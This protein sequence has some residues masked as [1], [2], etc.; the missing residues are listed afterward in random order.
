MKALWG[1]KGLCIQELTK[2]ES[3][4]LKWFQH[5]NIYDWMPVFTFTIF[6]KI[7]KQNSKFCFKVYNSFT[8]CTGNEI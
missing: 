2:F 7:C 5:L 3:H 4:R 6:S 8:W 1:N